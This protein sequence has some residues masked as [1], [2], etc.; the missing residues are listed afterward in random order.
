MQPLYGG[1]LKDV[2]CLIPI[3]LLMLV[4]MLIMLIM[5]IV[6]VVTNIISH[7]HTLASCGNHSTCVGVVFNPMV[8][9]SVLTFS[10]EVV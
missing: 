2:V 7:V 1:M 10:L 6:L 9:A 3:V 5:W 8:G 4:V